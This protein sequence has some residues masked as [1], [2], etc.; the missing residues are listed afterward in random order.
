[1]SKFVFAC[2]PLIGLLLI[3]CVSNTKKDVTDP[4]KVPVVAVAERRI[5]LDKLYVSDIQAVQNVEIRSRI[6]GF[7]EHIYVDEG[8]FVKK[9]QVLF[10][11]SDEEYRAEAD[12]AQASVNSLL[13]EAK[14]AELEVEKVKLLVEKK[15]VSVTE[16][17]VATARLH[18]MRARVQEARATLNHARARLS[19][20]VIR[21]PYD[22]VV[23]R[24]PLKVGS[25]LDE[26]TLITSVSDIS[27]V[28]AYFHISENEYLD[29]LRRRERHQ[30]AAA[31]DD[32]V[33]LI[34]AD[35]KEYAHTGRIETVV[36][37]FE[38]STGSIA[39]RA[40]FPNPQLMLKHGASGKVKLSRDVN[41]ALVLP[42]KAVFEI[43]DKNYVF[44]LDET[45]K[46]RMRNFVP[47]ARVDQFYI[48][49]SG[50]KRGE[51]IVY[52]GIQNIREGMQVAPK[53]LQL[54]SLGRNNIL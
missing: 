29:Y 47:K 22:G 39:F 13:A 37:E 43:Q 6:P 35:G 28:Y 45:N 27:A 52:E 31:E 24:I 11:I 50:L 18:A 25:L 23:D 14:T 42:Q 17:Q 51:K 12:K 3:S 40:R 46:V 41:N 9:G 1:M 36:S 48:V 32:E 19:Y 54:D 53:L 4:G 26:G 30:S 10:A 44:V 20:T 5:Q 21:A 34:L 15:I 16:L 38:E 49:E 2:I 7:L 33:T 8:R